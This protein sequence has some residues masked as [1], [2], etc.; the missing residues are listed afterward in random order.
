MASLVADRLE[1]GDVLAYGHRD[2]CGVGLRF[3]DSE[4]LY[5]LVVDGELPST[6]ELKQLNIAPGSERR[7][8]STKT[9]FIEWLAPLT[10]HDLS[11]QGLR[12]ERFVNNQ[13]ITRRRLYSFAHGESGR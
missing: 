7:V 5:D 12:P 8:F 10:D 3:V 2:Y 13:R 4:Y 9:A 11:G 6:A 1:R